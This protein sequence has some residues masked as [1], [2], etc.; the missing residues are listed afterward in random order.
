M[1]TAAALTATAPARG[2]R[3]AT[4]AGMAF[5]FEVTGDRLEIT[6][7]RR[8]ARV[9]MWFV[10]V[11]G[12]IGF[13][14]MLI[15]HGREVSVTCSRAEGQCHVRRGR[16]E[17]QLALSAIQGAHLAD[18]ALELDRA[19]EPPYHLCSAPRA[20]LAAA[21]EQLAVFLRAP[22]MATVQVRCESTLDMIVP[23]SGRIAGLLGMLV[24]LAL[25]GMFL[26]EAHTVVD[27][28]ARTIA[29]RGS[30]W[31][32]RR[33]AIERPLADVSAVV[34][35]RVY[36]GRGQRMYLID[37]QFN[38]GVTA[39][40]MSPAAYRVATLEEQIATLRAFVGST[41]PSGTA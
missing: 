15:P 22:A 23:L 9:L 20:Q 36:V 3:A 39:R 13:A 7:T 37:V 21:A 14:T 31:P 29:M 5:R 25:I 32:L 38:D 1:G 2:A 4:I 24:I 26:V 33:W 10:A 30:I 41:P 18:A 28:A 40:A 16:A 11:A 35:R 8:G 27:R 17:V 34:V 19:G 12:A 6:Q